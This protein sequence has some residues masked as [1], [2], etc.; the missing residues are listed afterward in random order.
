[1]LVNLRKD[2]L[3]NNQETRSKARD[4]EPRQIQRH[5]IE[6]I[7]NP[8]LNL[9]NLQQLIDLQLVSIILRTH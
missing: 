6:L 3:R 5:I 2:D 1:M 7:L 8:M 9:L 4:L